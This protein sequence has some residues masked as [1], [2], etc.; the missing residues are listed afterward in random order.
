MEAVILSVSPS[1]IAKTEQDN[2]KLGQRLKLLKDNVDRPLAAILS[3]NTIA[4]TVGAAGAGAQATA[5][6]GNVYVG[7]ISAILTFLILVI[8]EII[9]KTLGAIYWRRLTSLVV[10][11]IIPII[12][13]MW[14][15]VKM[16]ELITKMLGSGK[17]KPRIRR[18]EFIALSR[19]GTQ[20]GV[21][22]ENESRILKNLFRFNQL[23]A[24]DIMTP[25]TVIFAL[26]ENLKVSAVLKKYEKPQ[27]TR[28]PVYQNDIDNISGYVLRSDLLYHV[29]R[30][31]EDKILKEMSREMMAIPADL[32]L[33]ELFEKLIRRAEHMAL[34]IDEYGGTL[35]IVTLE[36]LLETLIGLEIMDETDSVEDMQKFARE[37]WERRVERLGIS[38]KN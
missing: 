5:V 38:V 11:I 23:S 33:D 3:L 21:L 36:D 34:I 18:E 9:P 26:E 10:R 2:K 16:A 30:S 27:F 1:F 31:Q 7:V 6:F 24:A 35:G 19:L 4:H 22:E 28:I 12:W 37:Q 17:H 29:L 13:I 8:S 20:E 32:G 25:R 14:P 15:L